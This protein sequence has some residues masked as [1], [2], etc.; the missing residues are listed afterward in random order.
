MARLY[1][2]NHGFANR[3]I[4]TH[5]IDRAAEDVLGKNSELDLLYDMPHVYI[6]RENHFGCN[7]WVHRNGTVRANGPS[8]MKEHFLFSTTGEPVFIPSSMST[9]A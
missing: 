6:H 5:H 3:V 1:N 7:M 2:R 9:P 4:L 8:R